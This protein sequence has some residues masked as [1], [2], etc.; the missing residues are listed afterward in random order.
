MTPHTLAALRV[1]PGNTAKHQG[2]C[3]WRLSAGIELAPRG[4]LTGRHDTANHQMHR[5]KETNRPGD[6]RPHSIPIRHRLSARWRSWRKT[7][8]NGTIMT[9][10]LKDPASQT[11]P[12]SVIG[13]DAP[14]NG[15]IWVLPLA[16]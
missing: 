1:Q 12:Q 16:A 7:S 10:Q 14:L 6:P 9:K 2:Q 15:I 4:F 5:S 3:I 13:L 8:R 11:L